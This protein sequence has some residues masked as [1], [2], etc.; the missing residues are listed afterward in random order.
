MLFAIECTAEIDVT[1][2][3]STASGGNVE[4]EISTTCYSASSIH[5]NVNRNETVDINSW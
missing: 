3:D 5:I 4:D 1:R 2:V